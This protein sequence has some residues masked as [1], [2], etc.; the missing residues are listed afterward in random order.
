MINHYNELLQKLYNLTKF[1]KVK[2]NL[3]NV[4][5]LSEAVGNPD[6][7][8][9][10]IHVGGTNGK[11]SVC[12]K[13]AKALQNQGYKVGLYTSPH[14]ASFRERIVINGAPIPEEKMAYLL[15]EL[16]AKSERLSIK[17]TFFELTTILAFLYF[18]QEKVDFAVIEVGLGGRLDS[19]NI[20]QPILS[21]VTSIGLDHCHLLGDTL[22]KIAAEKAG[23]MKKGVPMVV[24]ANAPLPVFLDAA[25]MMEAEVVQA[26]SSFHL[27]YDQENNETAK[28][29]LFCL[30]KAIKLSNESIAK[31]L[32]E[33]PKCRLEIVPPYVLARKLSPLPKAVVL[34]VAHNPAAFQ[35]LIPA[36]KYHFPQQKLRFVL[37]FSQDKDISGC[38]KIVVENAEAIHLVR[39]PNE[40]LADPEDVAY[41]LRSL[42]FL[43]FTTSNNA[44]EEIKNAAQQA[45]NAKEILVVTGSFFI[46][47][48]ARKALGYQDPQDEIEFHEK[49]TLSLS[50]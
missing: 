1:N 2:Q 43:K 39:T 14:I 45:V 46:M 23:I 9:K 35:K 32:M 36:L 17:P 44:P 22:E 8:F 4:R 24:G 38:L 6:L 20:L 40:R 29:A 27:F 31:A 12:L 49:Y 10:S 13:M 50:E 11:G 21:V 37:G 34:D 18:A 42:G 5:L 15:E 25:K 48:T 26:G 41:L 7:S 3:A 16:F 28:T 33:R 30:Q 47:N 19:T